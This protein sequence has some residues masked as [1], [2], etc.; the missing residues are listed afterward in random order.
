MRPKKMSRFTHERHGEGEKGEIEYFDTV[1]WMV[2]VKEDFFL[3]PRCI[4]EP[5]SPS[6]AAKALTASYHET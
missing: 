2:K 6:P 1:S 3:D 4:E 5:P